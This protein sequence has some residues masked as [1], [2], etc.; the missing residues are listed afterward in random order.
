MMRIKYIYTIFLFIATVILANCGFHPRGVL[1]DGNAG[2]FDSL[3]GTKF[4]IQS[5]GYH[6][7]INEL[8]HNLIA[9]KAIVI[10]NEEL[11]DY[12]INIQQVNQS[13][14][15]TSIVGGAS[16]N[17]YQLIYTITYNLVRPKIKIPVIPNTTINSQTFWQSNSGT[18][19]AQNNESTRIYNY[20]Q[21]NLVTRM[22]LQIA[23]LLPSKNIPSS[24]NSVQ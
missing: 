3:V 14:Q 23:E 24:D 17:T 16:N 22:I 6:S 15:L 11:A 2:N 8:R 1:A 18:Q 7:L 19:L 10:K 5:N 9:Y 12:I 13:S 21:S 20:L 4:Y